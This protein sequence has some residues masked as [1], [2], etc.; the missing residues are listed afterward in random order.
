M[1]LT[2]MGP[3]DRSR[4]AIVRVK[5]DLVV[6][7]IMAKVNTGTHRGMAPLV[8]AVGPGFVAPDEVHVDA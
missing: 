1:K 7:G 5:P 6:D 8:L 3:I 4:V 2:D